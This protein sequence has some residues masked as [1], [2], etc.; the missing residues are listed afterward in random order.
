MHSLYVAILSLSTFVAVFASTRSARA[1]VAISLAPACGTQA[2]FA[3]EL[4][5]QHALDL[6]AVGLRSI[7]M[8]AVPDSGQYAMTVEGPDGAREM[9]ADECATLW[10]AA[11]VIAAASARPPST[12]P[13]SAALPATSTSPVATPAPDV[14][15]PLV[16]E[17]ASGLHY[18]LAA[19]G[20]VEVN[21]APS[22]AGL[23]EAQGAMG[24]GPM[25]ASFTARYLPP[26]TT[27]T[28]TDQRHG[29]QVQVLG[30]R[31]G[32]S[33]HLTSWARVEAGLGVDRLGA[34]A[35]GVRRPSFDSVWVAAPDLE[36]AWLPVRFGA[37][38]CEL[39]LRGRVP[40]NRPRFVVEPEA[41]ELYRVPRFG[42][43][44]LFRIIW[45][46]R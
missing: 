41:T 1:E 11:L 31:L 43:T 24:L 9:I 39:A 7:V 28:L 40:L 16:E 4:R 19:A 23:V 30:A 20:G 2:A 34:E 37:V 18:W 46:G 3:Q 38:A 5:E 15:A 14:S 8:S 21:V 17:R 44:G 13:D 6:H 22:P 10:R 25:S 35:R 27:E 29:L 33:Y 32:V 26:S 36:L 45:G 12:G 42:A